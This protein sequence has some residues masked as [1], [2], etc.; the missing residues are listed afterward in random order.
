MKK[1]KVSHEVPLCLLEHST[2]YNDYQYCL[3]HLM[4][5]YED[6]KNFFLR[7][8]DE[9]VHIMMDNSL[10]ELG[11]PYSKDR[12]LYWLE[13]L[14][15][16]EFF[17]PDYW[18]DKTKSLVSAK[19][20]KQ[21][22]EQF[23]DTVFIP[24]VQGNS[25]DEALECFI[26]YKNNLGYKKIAFSYGANWYK[27]VVDYRTPHSEENIHTRSMLGRIEFI[28]ELYDLKFLDENDSIHLLGCQL[29]QEFSFY[30]DE[31]RDIIDTIDTSN[32]IMASIEGIEYTKFG[33]ESKPKTRIDDV[34]EIDISSIS[35][36]LL[37][38]NTLY[39]KTLNNL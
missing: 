28:N 19:E 21:Y 29:P 18:Q 22:E 8:R 35:I 6:Y 16:Q 7:C 1:I 25:K 3:P 34:M 23:P 20:W 5:K 33:M 31:V 30:D 2:Q 4:D 32:P 26:I 14:K 38:K 36:P 13:E 17:I 15:P 27:D 11:T 12:L 9:G 39:F 10:H 37:H 24:V